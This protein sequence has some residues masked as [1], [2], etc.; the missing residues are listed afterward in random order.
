MTRA[1]WINIFIN[2]SSTCFYMAFPCRGHFVAFVVWT[3]ASGAG[4]SSQ[5]SV[6]RHLFA[7]VEFHF[8]FVF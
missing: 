4:A 8:G 1:V 3:P 2:V 5:D 7:E 6:C